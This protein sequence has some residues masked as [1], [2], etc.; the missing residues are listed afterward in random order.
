MTP[1]DTTMPLLHDA[2]PRATYTE[3][4]HVLDTYAAETDKTAS[5]WLHFQDGDLAFRPHERSSSVE[6]I[7]R[8]QLLSERRFFGEFLD[9]PE[10]APDTLLPSA[11][12]VLGFSTRLVELARPR[13]DHLASRDTEWWLGPRPF[14]DVTRQRI[15]IFWRRVLHTAHH[16]TQLTVYLRLLDRAVPSVYGPTADITWAGADPTNT[17]AAAGRKGPSS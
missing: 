14:F 6:T 3:W 9:T 12:T 7:L 8:H 16:R 2:L 10:P 4:Q 5:V 15:W 1:N 17:T 13:L 11:P